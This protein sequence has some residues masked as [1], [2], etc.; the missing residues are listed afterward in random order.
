M[1]KLQKLF[2]NYFSPVKHNGYSQTKGCSKKYTSYNLCMQFFLFFF[3]NLNLFI[4]FFNGLNRF[5]LISIKL[6]KKF[7]F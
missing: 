1:I 6:S 2:K 5:N 4:F 7:D 3:L